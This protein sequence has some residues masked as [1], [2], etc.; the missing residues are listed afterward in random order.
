[1]R[2]HLALIGLTL[3]AL[4]L[5]D[6]LAAAALSSG[7][8]PGALVRYF[9]YGRSVPGKLAQW[10]A[11]PDMK[12]ALFD[13][14]WRGEK[15]AESRALFAAEA[16][17]AGPTVRG[18]GMSFVGHILTPAHELDPSLGLDLH[19]GP[20]APPNYCYALF[21]DD[22]AQRRPG[23]VAVLGIL[24]SSTAA[25][26]SMSNQTW[27]FEQ[28]APFTYPVFLPDGAS[29]LRAVEP[30][31]ATA[32]QQRA[33]LS[34]P[35][36]AAAWAA[37]LAAEDLLY[38]PEAYA[39]PGLD[40]SPFARLVRRSLATDATRRAEAAVLAE[41]GTYPWREVLARMI[42]DFVETAR[43]DGQVPVVFLI[44]G[45]DPGDPDLREAALP[46]LQAL[47]APYLA[48]ADVASPRDGAN[49]LG[50]GHLTPAAND[51]LAARFLEI[52]AAQGV[53]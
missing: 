26:A 14:A 44:Q 1:M 9:E 24:S 42:R 49:Y 38:A 23:D 53:R 6:L 45:R 41:D 35:A 46:V 27:N 15:I 47:D 33:A 4:V 22:R 5:I 50:D 36:Q 34:D 13:V 11:H 19:G 52:L 12:G 48:T 10:V 8:A 43:A 18:Y 3:L 32:E 7:A 40:I 21:L 17:D 2:R 25:M 39:L 51:L 29:G 16:P 28:P 20:S 37:Q 30:R 31:V